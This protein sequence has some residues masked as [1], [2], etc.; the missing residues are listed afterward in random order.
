MDVDEVSIQCSGHTGK[1]VVRLPCAASLAAKSRCMSDV[2]PAAASVAG[3][4]AFLT[5]LLRCQL[6]VVRRTEFCCRRL[7]APD[8]TGVTAICWW[9]AEQAG[10]AERWWPLTARG[11]CRCDALW[12][13]LQQGLHTARYAHSH[14]A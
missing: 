13:G 14:T 4:N 9:L 5:M 2:D 7:E 12:R 8:A 3:I 11:M 6:R 1:D 10:Q